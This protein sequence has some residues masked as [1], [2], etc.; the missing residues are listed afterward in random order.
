[1]NNIKCNNC[2]FANWA[3][4]ENCRKCHVTLAESAPSTSSDNPKSLPPV[5]RK[6]SAFQILKNDALSF[7]VI[8][9]PVVMWGIYIA[10]TFFGVS[11]ES[12]RSE[13]VVENSGGNPIFLI[14]P[15]VLTLLGAGLLS[16]R[17]SSFN[18]IFETG[19]RVVGKITGVSFIKD[20]GRIE[21]SYRYKRQKFQSGSSIM[22][23]SKT[24]SY[25]HG[26][27]VVLIIDSVNPNK[28]L[29]QDLYI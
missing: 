2:G 26:D 10:V 7:V 22:K 17:I 28:V 15:I 13:T 4:A 3:T 11:F 8:I 14:A 29:I 24:Q 6:P 12:K 25:R 19:E 16:W 23:N 27:D 9:L 18:K 5:I 21:F 20:R 1:M